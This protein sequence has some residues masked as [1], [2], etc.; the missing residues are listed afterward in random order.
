MIDDPKQ[1]VAAGYD[2]IAD[3]YLER[4]GESVVRREWLGRLIEN[5]QTAGSRVLDLG[6]G[7]G[8]PVVRD[9]AALGHAVVGIDASAQ[10]IA[11]ARV[12]VPK[13][14]FVHADM[15]SVTFDAN[16]FDAV[17]AFYAITH[18]PAGQQEA[19]ISNIATWLRPG[20]VFVASFGSGAAGEWAGEWLGTTMFFGHT[21][22]AETSRFLADAKLHVR[23]SAIQKQDN[24]DAAFLW[25]EATKES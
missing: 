11:R 3:V 2:E 14:T 16:N 21:G 24:E 18:V 10:Q 6:C 9:L 17:G 12:N 7:A 22:K 23:S 1:L 13:A 25:I 20:G 4:F 8:I 15:C 19:L 5:L